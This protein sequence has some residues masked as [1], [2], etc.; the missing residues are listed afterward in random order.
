[1][2]YDYMIQVE[3]LTEPIGKS[4]YVAKFAYFREVGAEPDK[5][6]T[7][8]FDEAWGETEEEAIAKL[9]AMVEEWETDQK[10]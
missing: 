1:M 3:P 5:K 4:R 7:P 2:T 9:R 8:P 10:A 6:V